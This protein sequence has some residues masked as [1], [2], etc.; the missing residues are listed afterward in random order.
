[1]YK[2]YLV[3]FL[4]LTLSGCTYNDETVSVNAS[5]SKIVQKKELY[6]A[7]LKKSY[8]LKKY[9]PENKVYSGILIQ[10]SSG[11]FIEEFERST[12]IKNAIYMKKIRFGDKF[13]LS[14]VL[15]SYVNHK[16][17][18]IIIDFPENK[19]IDY[20]YNKDI[21]KS[22]AKDFG[23]LKIP[24][25]VSIYPIS[26]NLI[27]NKNI[28]KDRHIKFMQD[29]S[30][31]FKMYAQDISILQS[32]NSD[33]VYNFRDY[34]AGD[35]YTN[36]ISINIIQNIED[37]KI[38]KS[39]K[40]LD[41][42]YQ[43]FAHKMPIAINL[44]IS[45]YSGETYLYKIDEKIRELNR[46]F[47]TIPYKYP[48][49]KM[50]NYIN[51]DTFDLGLKNKQDYVLHDNKKILSSYIKLTSTD[52]FTQNVIYSDNNRLV[53]E[54]NRLNIVIYKI[55]DKFYIRYTNDS[56]FNTNNIKSLEIDGKKYYNIDDVLKINRM[57]KVVDYK[58]KNI[59]LF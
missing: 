47:G 28:K 49:V 38:E 56:Y 8:N 25:F 22:M 24:I 39:F 16:T 3:I 48:R 17:P 59:T 52:K 15:N 55:G 33:C 18:Y 36:W 19:S 27:E 10:D 23:E 37:D 44:S 5:T 34:Y 46:F 53:P 30:T 32:V 58:N 29:V 40:E 31:Y 26:K 12:G 9:E 42:L 2:I 41:F 14:F 13:P 54:N 21:L 4:S 50:I 1:M 20:A 35:N 6:N 43:N 57:Q 45:H 51:V 11:D 7:F